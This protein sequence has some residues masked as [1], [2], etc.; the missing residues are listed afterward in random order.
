MHETLPNNSAK[1]SGADPLKLRLITVGAALG[2]SLG[3][4]LDHIPGAPHRPIPLA[5]GLGVNRAVTSNLLKALSQDNPL[6]ILHVIPGPEPLRKIT[7]RLADGRA[8]EPLLDAAAIAIDAFDRLIRDEAGTRPAL[9]A[10]IAPYLPGARAKLELASRYAVF[11]GI[12]QLK[13]VQGEL[14]IGTAVITP[15][16][17]DPERLDLTWL[18]G[19]SAI[20]RMRPGVDVRFSYRFPQKPGEQSVTELELGPADDVTSLEQFC[21]NPPARLMARSVGDAIYYH[22]PDDILGPKDKVDMFVVDHHPASMRRFADPGTGADEPQLTALFVE[23]AIPVA[24]L[25]FDV[26]LHEDVFPSADAQLYFYDTGYNGVANVNDK[27]RDHERVDQ[28]ATLEILS[29]GTGGLGTEHLPN[30]LPM[31]QHMAKRHDWDLAKFR[32]HRLN[33]QYPVLG[34]QVSMAFEKPMPPKTDQ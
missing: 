26:I 25:V 2:A 14:W 29:T 32:G 8:T 5:K 6:E 17:T 20:Q 9:D 21:A 13:G 4:I 15:S 10:L 18:N 23:I 1:P 33:L 28:V 31:L 34:W 19:A 11:K 16:P 27:S 12:S 3:A 22:L 24:N 30:Y 7:A